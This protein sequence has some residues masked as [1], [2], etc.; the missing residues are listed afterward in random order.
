[1]CV[2]YPDLLKPDFAIE[3]PFS[4]TGITRNISERTP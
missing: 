3:A 4:S 2:Y 1:M